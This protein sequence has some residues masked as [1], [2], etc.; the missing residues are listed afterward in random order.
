MDNRLT[1]GAYD[2]EPEMELGTVQIEMNPARYVT[3][4]GETY[5]Q[6]RMEEEIVQEDGKILK[7]VTMDTSKARVW[8]PPR[9]AD[10]LTM[11]SRNESSRGVPPVARVVKTRG[12]EE[13]AGGDKPAVVRK[14]V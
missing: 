10:A 1:K 2:F 7:R 11:Q 12:L 9:V 3:I 6:R 8:V 4:N 13:A 5:F 14:K